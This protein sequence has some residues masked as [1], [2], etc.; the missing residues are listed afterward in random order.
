MIFREAAIVATIP[1][2]EPRA[3]LNSLDSERRE[4]KTSRARRNVSSANVALVVHALPGVSGRKVT[5]EWVV[6]SGLSSFIHRWVSARFLSTTPLSLPPKKLK[7]RGRA[8]SC[9]AVQHEADG[10]HTE[11]AA[12]KSVEN[13]GQRGGAPFAPKKLGAK[14]EKRWRRTD[15]TA[16]E[17]ACSSN[18]TVRLYSFSLPPF[19]LPFLSRRAASPPRRSVRREIYEWTIFLC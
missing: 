18:W 16:L 2:D 19:F 9:P 11:R 1:A 14:V 5:N 7:T 3:G 10:L 17:F 6:N 13:K 12:D 4:G 15:R 8:T